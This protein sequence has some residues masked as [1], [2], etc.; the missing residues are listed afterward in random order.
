MRQWLPPWQVHLKQ[1][2]RIGDLIF[3]SVGDFLVSE[4]FKVAYENSGLSGIKVFNPTQ[5]ISITPKNICRE[6]P[7]FYEAVVAISQARVLFDQMEVTWEREPSADFCDL[8]GPGGGGKNGNMRVLKV[9]LLIRTG[10]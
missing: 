3:G 2:Q 8:C 10:R 7:L 5:V 1:S 9:S 4:R 6:I